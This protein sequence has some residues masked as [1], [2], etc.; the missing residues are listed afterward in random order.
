M[1]NRRGSALIFGLLVVTFLTIAGAGFF[2]A[3]INES[4]M[5]RRSV[6]STKAFW[7]AEAGA[8][9]A[10]WALPA[11]QAGTLESG[12]T[13]SSFTQQLS[14]NY[15]QITSTGTYTYPDGGALTR[16]IQAIASTVLL[17]PSKFK[18]ALET[19]VRLVVKG[20]VSINPAGSSLEYATINFNDLF[21]MT[22]EDVKAF[23][24]IYNS[25][26]AA[27][28]GVVWLQPPTGSGPA[29]QWDLTS[30]LVGHGILI[31]EGDIHIA[32]TVNWDGIIYVMGKL[33]MSGTP[34]LSGT[35][36]AE[37]G[38]T[39]DDTT[40]TGNVTC[41]YDLQKIADALN[42]LTFATAKVVSWKE[43]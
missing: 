17:D 30:D 27:M 2:Y 12:V 38:V 43:I 18:Y 42:L 8:A 10:V 32:G 35:V 13:F 4:K 1:D 7:A 23:A 41:N 21:S 22:K 3:S 37:S 24:T 34:I 19:T 9:Q 15:Y 28:S 33:R 6:D 31:V 20:S 40:V 25:I 39:V 26:P 11:A 16:R 14:P 36:L 29:F 5:T